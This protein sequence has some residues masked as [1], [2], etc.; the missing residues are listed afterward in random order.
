MWVLKITH[1][2]TPVQ[3]FTTS[4][5]KRKMFWTCNSI[6]LF[7]S[8]GSFVCFFFLCF[9]FVLFFVCFVFCLCV[10]FFFFVY[11][12]CF[13]CSFFFRFV[14][15]FVPF[16]SCFLCLFL[17][18]YMHC[19]SQA[20]LMLPSYYG[21]GLLSAPVINPMGILIG[22]LM[23]SDDCFNIIRVVVAYWLISHPGHARDFAWYRGQRPSP[24]R[25]IKMS[26]NNNSRT[27]KCGGFVS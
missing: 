23:F 22:F 19:I 15:V 17:N 12:F 5:W 14:S 9:L 26:H 4:A 6:H 2:K 13:V 20:V 27:R 11:V 18:L 7:V 8:F 25:V 24:A 1:V 10:F 21:K 16:F 3:P